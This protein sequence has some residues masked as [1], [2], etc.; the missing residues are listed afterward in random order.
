MK[1]RPGCVGKSLDDLSFSARHEEGL[2]TGH[3]GKLGIG[4]CH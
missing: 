4:K 1:S 2:L 3:G